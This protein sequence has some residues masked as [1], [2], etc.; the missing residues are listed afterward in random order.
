MPA[1]RVILIDSQGARVFRRQERKLTIEAEF[2]DGPA[3]PPAIDDYLRSVGR[4]DFTLI[5]NLAD[6]TCIPERLPPAGRRDRQSLAARRLAS[7][8]PGQSL[9]L[10]Q[11]FTDDSLPRVNLLLYAQAEVPAITNWRTALAR[12]GCGIAGI[13]PLAALMAADSRQPA[14]IACRTR[15]GLRITLALQGQFAF[16]R[17]AVEVAGDIGNGHDRREQE[18]LRTKTYLVAQGLIAEGSSAAAA[19]PEFPD[20][21]GC[22]SDCLDKRPGR[23]LA[24]PSW[25]QD[26][27]RHRQVRRLH[28]ATL[29]AIAVA[30]VPLTWLASQ[31]ADIAGR[32]QQTSGRIMVLQESL[33]RTVGNRDPTAITEAAALVRLDATLA[34]ARLQLAMALGGLGA[35][36]DHLPALELRYL[37]WEQAAPGQ[38][39]RLLARLVCASDAPAGC[40]PERESR[41][42]VAAIEARRPAIRASTQNG[43]SDDGRRQL[44]VT[45]TAETPP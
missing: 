7:R 27:H 11:L 42:V 2:P 31:L 40:R 19:A 45:I 6:E 44:E 24:A 41:A 25:R 16:T 20:E 38:P 5:L 4:A 8:L 37:G 36:L 39:V 29:A 30:S 43:S 22:I 10:A 21:L 15:T 14:V 23:Q 18:V 13:W 17:L 9:V 34:Q 3:T 28:L 33:R 26:W 12:S 35:A 1:E 32:Q